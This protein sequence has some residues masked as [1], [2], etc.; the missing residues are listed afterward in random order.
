VKLDVLDLEA[1]RVKT[2]NKIKSGIYVRLTISDTGHGMD[3]QTM[4]RIFE[5]FFT[6]K[7][8]GSGSG[9]GLS[10]VHGIVSNYS[11]AIEV[12]SEPG[13][14]SKFMIYLPQHSSG[15]ADDNTTM[16]ITP[17]GNERILFVDD[18][19][20]I[21]YMGKKMLESLGYSVDIRTDGASALRELR[22]KTQKYDLM[23]TDQAM[24]KM[25]GTELVKEARKIR[26]D[27]KVIIITG[28]K[29]S[30]PKNA[31]RDLNVSEII[32][33]PLILSDFSNLIR[34]VLDKKEKME[35]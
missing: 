8:V 30:I 2:A 19:K 33:K 16:D 17:K 6:K 23:V 27:L 14:G 5:P 35:V 11:G 22:K 28:F 31:M 13:K 34:E 26:P 4:D 21:T 9:L 32:L 24:P 15:R 3:K 20:E 1:H 10:V 29:D 12:E 18:E 25:L 7:E